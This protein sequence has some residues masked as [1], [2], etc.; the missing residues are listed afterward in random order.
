MLHAILQI[1]LVM[2]VGE[3]GAPQLSWETHYGKAI[4]SARRHSKPL[5]V[6]IENPAQPQQRLDETRLLEGAAAAEKLEGYELCRVDASTD[7]G[8]KVAQAF[9]AR[10]FPY[11]AVSD[12]R[13]KYLTYRK[14]GQ[15]SSDEWASAL[16]SAHRSAAPAAT[17]G[18]SVAPI[19]SSPVFAV[20]SRTPAYC[21]SCQLR[22]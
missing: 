22:R 14:A 8:K 1:C 4:E 13:S 11:T 20:P 17:Q 3:A 18:V 16:A 21:P 15:L 7:Y 10:S 9:G 12:E 6:V 19:S 5:V 2:A